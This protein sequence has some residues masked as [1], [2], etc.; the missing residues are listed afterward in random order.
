MDL[1]KQWKVM[2]VD[3]ELPIREE[4]REMKLWDY[5]YELAGEA[6]NGKEALA[7]FRKIK[8]DIVITDITMPVMDGLELIENLEKEN[9]LTKFIILTCH[10]DFEFARKAIEHNA[11]DYLLK[12]DICEAEIIRVLDKAR[13]AAEKE[14]QLIKKLRDENRIKISGYS[15]GEIE[16]PGALENDFR[17]LGFQIN[18]DEN[19]YYLV[20]ENRLGSWIFVE[21]MVREYLKESEEIK[22]WILL[23][24]GIYGIVL[25]NP[26]N[27]SGVIDKLV[28]N[29]QGAFPFVNDSFRF[30]YCCVQQADAECK[31]IRKGEGGS[32][33][34]EG[35]GLLLS[36]PNSFP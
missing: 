35:G 7:V 27:A 21:L 25:I 17:K 10:Q 29:I 11:V 14:Q 30:F 19:N 15:I 9:P 13:K 23:D 20:M 1:S 28:E 18:P 5:G 12:A 32:C 6:V 34:M 33:K 4:I 26:Y 3:D 22:S 16:N 31:T 8:P 2:V 24:D 36:C